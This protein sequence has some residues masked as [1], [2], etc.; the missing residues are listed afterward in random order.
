MESSIFCLIFRSSGVLEDAIIPYFDLQNI[1]RFEDDTENYTVNFHSHTYT[2][3]T[4]NVTQTVVKNGKLA[5]VV[6][7]SY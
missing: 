5:I 3:G 6:L 4:W 7:Q 2:H 1:S